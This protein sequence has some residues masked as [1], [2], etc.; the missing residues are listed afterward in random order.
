MSASETLTCSANV[1]DETLTAWHDGFL[2]GDART[3]LAAHVPSACPASR[4]W[5][6]LPVWMPWW[7][8]SVCR[9]LGP[10]SSAWHPTWDRASACHQV[11]GKLVA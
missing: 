9:W 7:A 6:G 3:A 4:G 11:H 5:P 1:T 2:T 8:L 10:A